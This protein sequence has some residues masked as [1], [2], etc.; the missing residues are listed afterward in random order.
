MH[1][2]FAGTGVGGGFGV[3]IFIPAT[4][5]PKMPAAF[6][7]PWWYGDAAAT[8]WLF[9][10]STWWAQVRWKSHAREPSPTTGTGVLAFYILIIL[11][12]NASQLK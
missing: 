2:L 8:A 9:H 11:T 5:L 3:R 7:P 1:W 12:F 6:L 4:W 10:H